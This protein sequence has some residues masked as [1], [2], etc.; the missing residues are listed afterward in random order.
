MRTTPPIMATVIAAVI[1]AAPATASP[2]LGDSS[3]RASHAAAPVVTNGLVLLTGNDGIWVA[4][5][6]GTGKRR[7]FSGSGITEAV[8]S[9]DG[10]RIAFAWAVGYNQDIYTIPTSGGS[11]TRVTT[12]PEWDYNPQWSGDGK[13][14]AFSSMRGWGDMYQIN[15]SAPFGKPTNLSN[16]TD[17]GGPCVGSYGPSEVHFLWH[18][19]TKKMIV[20][21]WCENY[22]DYF[23]YDGFF[24]YGTRTWGRDLNVDMTRGDFSPDGLRLAYSY[25]PIKIRS[26]ATGSTQTLPDV[27][28]SNP[29]WSPDGKLFA[30]RKGNG[31]AMDAY[32]VRTDGTRLRLFLNGLAPVDWA[33]R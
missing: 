19:A 2:I 12:N 7:V 22:E 29:I 18:P 9:P 32:F 3:A 4:Y 31:T 24:N 20:N 26:V 1:A 8:F 25:G 27:G 16:S 17:G 10:K 6:D 15:S 5:P 21:W 23:I 14:I 30:T 28:V 13:K 33:A 11:P